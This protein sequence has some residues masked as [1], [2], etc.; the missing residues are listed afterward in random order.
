MQHVLMSVSLWSSV[1]VENETFFGFVPTFMGFS[2]ITIL[3]SPSDGKP[4]PPAFGTERTDHQHVCTL[5]RHVDRVEVLRLEDHG[6]PKK[7]KCR[8]NGE[9]PQKTMK[10]SPG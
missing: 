8:E 10:I 5:R 7:E 9:Q 6:G 2:N 3:N 4:K 1:A